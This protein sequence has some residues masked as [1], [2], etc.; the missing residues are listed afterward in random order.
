MESSVAAE[1]DSNA[2]EDDVKE[3]CWNQREALPGE[4]RCVICGRYGEYICDETDDDICS[5]ECKGVLLSRLAKSRQPTALPCPA[6]LPATDECYY[7][8]DNDKS[9]VNPLTTDQT[10][11]LRRKLDILVKGDTTPPPILSF[12][13]CKLPQKLLENIE[14]AGYEMPTPVQMQAIPAALARQS[15]LVSAETGSGKTGSF[16]IP[17]VSQCAKVNED[18]FQN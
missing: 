18:H 16:L 12:A 13:S 17:V 4:P 8:R 10:Q 1:S 11:L 3:R 2:P 7:V 5:L 9:E 14:V 6:K 15:L